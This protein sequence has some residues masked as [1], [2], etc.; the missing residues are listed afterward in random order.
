MDRYDVQFDHLTLAVGFVLH[1]PAADPVTGVVAEPGKRWA[2]AESFDQ[3]GAGDRV[4][5]VARD[6]RRRDLVLLGQF[7]G[8]LFK[9]VG[10][11]RDERYAVPTRSEL[12]SHL[13][14][15]PRRSAGDQNGG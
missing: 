12:A 7:S 9:S 2:C 14:T 4:T 10:A 5:K 15:D 8:Q 3:F 13:G 11:A 6:R 1:E